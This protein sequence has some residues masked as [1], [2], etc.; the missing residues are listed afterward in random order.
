MIDGAAALQLQ[1]AHV[2]RNVLLIT[3]DQFRADLLQ[4]SFVQTPNLDALI[5]DGAVCFNQHY[6]QST[7]CAPARAS[8]HTGCYMMSHQVDDNGA[9]LTEALTNWAKEAKEQA[10][11]VPTLIGYVDQTVDT[12]THSAD[13]PKLEDW[14]GGHLP[15]LTRLMETD[16]MGTKEWLKQRGIPTEGA[17]EAHGWNG[18]NG[19]TWWIEQSRDSADSANGSSHPK[20]AAYSANDTDTRVLTDRAIQFIERQYDDSKPTGTSADGTQQGEPPGWMLHL[21]LR[22]PH[23]PWVAPE[24][25]NS[26]YSCADIAAAAKTCAT[27]ATARAASVA[28]EANT[29]E[30]LRMIHSLGGEG[31]AGK[32]SGWHSIHSACFIPAC[33]AFASFTPKFVHTPTPPTHSL[34]TGGSSK[35]AKNVT[36]E[37]LL[38]AKSAYFAL[39]SEVDANLGRL[40]NRMKTLQ[41]GAIGSS[42]SG[43]CYGETLI[44]FTS[45]HAEQVLQIDR[46]P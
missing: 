30:W 41:R 32:L 21:S 43:S 35:T 8:L 1:P 36:N 29:H 23:P 18:Y 7:P 42:A 46:H 12:R 27:C 38:Q 3:A 4:S 15:G 40:F 37:E 6:C 25:F 28:A 33:P 19:D 13:D 14:E 22:A 39:V 11:Y 34:P 26:M 45:D 17:P 10:G 24:P 2:P 31:A 5:D 16:S 20:P 44:I 9:P